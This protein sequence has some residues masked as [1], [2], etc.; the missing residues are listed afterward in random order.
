VSGSLS[1]A[2]AS[3]I[4]LYELDAHATRLEGTLPPELCAAW[5][6]LQTLSLSNTAISGPVPECVSQW[7]QLSLL[8]SVPRLCATAHAPQPFDTRA[9]DLSHT[10]VNATGTA[11]FQVPGRVKLAYCAIAYN[12]SVC[13]RG[14]VMAT[15]LDLSGN[16]WNVTLNEALD[17]I[18]GTVFH[19]DNRSALAELVMDDMG[20]GGT[21]TSYGLDFSQLERFSAARN[22]FTAD[23][24]N[25]EVYC[26]R[27]QA[28]T[29]LSLAGNP[30]L[31]SGFALSLCQA[32]MPS[33]TSLD[34]S[35]T[36][37]SYC[38]D[39]WSLWEGLRSAS[40][41]GVRPSSVCNVAPEARDELASF[42]LCSS[43]AAAPLTGVGQRN[44]SELYC[45]KPG[46]RVLFSESRLECP[47]WSTTATAGQLQLTVD[48]AF[49]LFWG[50]RCPPG[51]F[52]GYGGADDDILA[53]IASEHAAMDSAA[54]QGANETALM[55]RACFPCPEGV[56]C[57]ALAAVDAP[58][59]LVASRFPLFSPAL[60]ASAGYAPDR[61]PRRLLVYAP[62]VH[63]LHPT[64][65]N[66]VPD[67][68]VLG[69]ATDWSVWPALMQS[70]LARDP[71]FADFQCRPGHDARSLMCST[72]EA[73][74]WLDGF[75]C[76][77]CVAGAAVLSPLAV[78]AG[79]AALT[80]H[81]LAHARR[82][83]AAELRAPESLAAQRVDEQTTT[84]VLWF[85]QASATLR[86]SAQINAAQRG[87]GGHNTPLSDAIDD[88]LSF[89]P[90][91]AECVLGTAWSISRG[92]VTLLLLPWAVA[93][94]ALVLARA[95]PRR[96]G[97]VELAAVMVLDILFT[98]VV[99]RA[100][101]VFNVRHE[102]GQ[103][104][105]GRAVAA[106]S[107]L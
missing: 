87:E 89:R 39:D 71:R 11:V 46:Q 96:R 69:A 18:A 60:L 16:A 64:V 20:L 105:A 102:A 104:W 41:V 59:Q 23:H 74:F 103:V 63:C 79:L 9:Q 67:G 17:C 93:A 77:P 1:P 81:I 75:L 25:E 54:P 92:T 50:C 7:G 8:V 88:I 65:C 34:L 43:S 56:T 106:V 99:Q 31:G 52:W 44:L 100:V 85:F 84:L 95:V 78:V 21:L 29:A 62:S 32:A 19:T 49:L 86:A 66:Y 12:R 80:A 47:A 4:Y 5:P 61:R 2:L 24:L 36:D 48:A 70:G 73:G 14:S 97:L 83:T 30:A 98:P 51:Q 101:E 13:P 72:C 10:G 55:A 58:H 90:W 76:R 45:Q 3:W 28:L 57:S 15:S 68:N 42:A 91:A 27:G 35:H 6:D 40:L 37:V 53:A 22:A 82:L 107:V 94:A 38:Y 26:T 33:L